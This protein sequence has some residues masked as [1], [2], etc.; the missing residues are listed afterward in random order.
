MAG[1]VIVH[2]HSPTETPQI[3][4]GRIGVDTGAYATGVLTAVRLEGAERTIL[5]VQAR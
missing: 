2:G 1:R 4:Q 5:Q 3:E